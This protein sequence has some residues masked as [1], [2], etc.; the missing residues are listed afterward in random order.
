MEISKALRFIS[1]RSEPNFYALVEIQKV[2]R[3]TQ[4]Q[5]FMQSI[6]NWGPYIKKSEPISK[7]NTNKDL[8]FGVLISKNQNPF[9]NKIQIRTF[10]IQLE[11]F[12]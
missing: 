12:A 2:L 11:P 10:I 3:F 5:F 7:Q 8:Y 6:K 1:F 4:G 9:Q